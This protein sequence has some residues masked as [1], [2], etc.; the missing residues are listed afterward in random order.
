ME[1]TR[2]VSPSSAPRTVTLSPRR[3]FTD[4]CGSRPYI[5]LF[6]SSYSAS[7][8][9]GTLFMHSGDSANASSALQLLDTTVP[10]HA[11]DV[12]AEF[13]AGLTEL[14]CPAIANGVKQKSDTQQ[15]KLP[16]TAQSALDGSMNL[17]P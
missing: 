6:V 5:T 16:F 8:A 17:R 11:L 7:F 1:A 9:P 13:L 14:P 4:S 10:D 15:R 12:V 2:I 3:A